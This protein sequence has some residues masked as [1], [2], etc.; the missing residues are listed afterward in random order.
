M[1]INSLKES[2]YIFKG[3]CINVVDGDTVDVNLNF[4]FDITAKRRLRLL[5]T[6]TPERGQ[7]LY[8]EAKQFVI[9]K[10]FGLE[11]YIQTYKSDTFGRYLANIYYDDDGKIKCLN[12]E[13]RAH[14]LLKENSKWNKENKSDGLSTTKDEELLHTT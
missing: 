3:K 11:V 9:D 4:G 8:N 7:T 6:D 5:N 14:G 10:I 13:L 1:E 12:D 2:L